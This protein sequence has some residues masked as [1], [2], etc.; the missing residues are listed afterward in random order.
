MVYY[1]QA[2]LK[3]A[4]RV[5][6][7]GGRI[8]ILEFSHVQ[9]PLLRQIYD[10]YS[11]NVIPRIG[12]LV[13]NDSES[14]QYLVESIRRFP[15]QVIFS[16]LLS[17]SISNLFFNQNSEVLLKIFYGSPKPSRHATLRT[18]LLPTPLQFLCRISPRISHRYRKSHSPLFFIFCRTIS[19]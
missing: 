18:W 4:Y 2:A 14:Y 19:Y 9:N 8:M 10:T 16:S 11:F 6:R 1:I 13:A 3:E 15:T 5:L 12:G 7:S 17:S